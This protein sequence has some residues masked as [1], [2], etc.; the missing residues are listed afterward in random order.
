M[1]IFQIILNEL[2]LNFHQKKDRVSLALSL[3]M[4]EDSESK[5]TS[6]QE[7]L[8]CHFLGVLIYFDVKFISKTL[9]KDKFLL[10]LADLFR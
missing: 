7:Y 9:R 8:Q 5:V 2:L 4:E 6:V 1:L 10:S 3:L